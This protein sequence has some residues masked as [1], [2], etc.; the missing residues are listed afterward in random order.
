[1]QLRKAVNKEVS[2]TSVYF[3]NNSELK[4]FP[5]RME[6]EGRQYSFVES[7]LRFQINDSNRRM[8]LFDMTDGSVDYRLKFDANKLTWTLLTITQP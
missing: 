3:R 5:R 6:Y 2:V 1:M 8:S 4:S 7:G